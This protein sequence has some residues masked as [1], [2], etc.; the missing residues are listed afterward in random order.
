MHLGDAFAE[1]VE[2]YRGLDIVAITRRVLP[3]AEYIPVWRGVG[4]V[5]VGHA[6]A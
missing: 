1:M 3:D 5:L 2:R 4:Y 6:P